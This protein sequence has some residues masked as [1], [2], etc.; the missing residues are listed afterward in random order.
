[1]RRSAATLAMV[2]GLILLAPQGASGEPEEVTLKAR[3]GFELI[4]TYIPPAKE[5]AAGVILMHMY[6]GKRQD[7]EPLLAGLKEAGYAVLA[8]D[9]RGHGQSKA[10]G[11]VDIEKLSDKKAEA[12]CA[13]LALDAAAAAAFLDGRPEVDASRLALIGGSVGANVCL[14]HAVRNPAVK[15]IVLLSPGL[16]YLGIESKSAMKAC[17]NRPIF[18]L[19]SRPDVD[20]VKCVETLADV[21]KGK[22]NIE[23]R[24][25]DSKLQLGPNGPVLPHGTDLMTAEPETVPAVLQWLET[26]L[27]PIAEEAGK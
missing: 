19:A 3:D 7:W 24:I 22:K 27:P 13:G 18:M 26:T 16:D 23:S 2:A 9:F 21:A 25:F 15:A 10:G 8:F 14:N 17:A 1:M 6:C 11:K 5:H 20:S 4:A 12:L